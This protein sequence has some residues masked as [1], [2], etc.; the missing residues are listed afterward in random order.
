[1]AAEK[2]TLKQ[3][4]WELFDDIVGSAAPGGVHTSPWRPADVNGP[5]DAEPVY[6][7]DYATLERLLAVPPT[8]GAGSQSGVPALALDVWLAYELRRAGFDADSVWP[9]AAVPRIL[10]G[11][12]AKLLAAANTDQRKALEP[13][14]ART[15]LKGV[16]GSSAKILGKNYDKQVDVVISAW[17]TGPELL[18]STKRMDSSYGKNAPNRVEESYGDAKNLRLRH[19]LAALG[20]VFGLNADILVKEPDTHEWLTD[21]LA[22]LGREDDAYHGTCLVMIE[23]AVNEEEWPSLS[24]GDGSPLEASAEAAV[25]TFVRVR[26]DLVPARLDAGRFLGR[27]IRRVLDTAPVTYHREAR[28]RI[29]TVIVPTGSV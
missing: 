3:W 28:A 9:R 11:P 27:L 6:E 17:E 18:I 15:S 24:G 10:P 5:D 21:Q 8:L 19:P 25:R 29:R 7:P 14:L 2:P 23:T 26:C 20:F 16:S 22:K 12:V 1:M 4:A 13:L